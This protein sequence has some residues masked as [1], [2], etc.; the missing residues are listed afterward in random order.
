MK[1][2]DIC[3]KFSIF[4]NH[5]IIQNNISIYGFEQ[6]IN[7]N[8]GRSK[9]NKVKII[10]RASLCFNEKCHNDVKSNT[11]IPIWFFVRIEKT[12]S[13]A[14]DRHQVLQ[15]VNTAGLISK[16]FKRLMF[17]IDQDLENLKVKIKRSENFGLIIAIWW[18][19]W[20]PSKGLQMFD[21][22]QG[23][24]INQDFSALEKWRQKRK[25]FSKIKSKKR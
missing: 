3:L 13:K 23:H 16:K 15:L 6:M 19:K 25:I 24:Q 22:F 14:T 7:K 9:E 18:L 2:F 17:Y 21:A 12:K 1:L 8:F 20:S 11:K 10:W 5:E 4:S